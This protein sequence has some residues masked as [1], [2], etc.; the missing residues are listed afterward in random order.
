MRVGDSVEINGLLWRIQ[1]Y[2]APTDLYMLEDGT[3]RLMSMTAPDLIRYMHKWQKKQKAQAQ[4][5]GPATTYSTGYIT[6]SGALTPQNLKQ[7]YASLQQ[8][9][10]NQ[11]QYTGQWTIVDLDDEDKPP[12]NGDG[13]N[14]D[15]NMAYKPLNKG[16]VIEDVKSGGKRK[17]LVLGR[18]EDEYYDLQFEGKKIQWSQRDYQNAMR[19]KAV[20]IIRA[21]EPQKAL[22]LSE[23]DKAVLRPEAREDVIA[24]IMQAHKKELIFDTWGLGET[25]E[26]GKGIGMLFEGGPGTG[27]TWLAHCIAKAL[28]QELMVVTTG[29][30]QSSLAGQTNKNIENAFKAAREGN[31]ILFLDECDS[32]IADRKHLGMILGSEI[33]TILTCIEKAEGIT[34]LATNRIENLDPALDRR[35]ALILNFPKPNL[36]ERKKIWEI[37]IPKKMPLGEGV[38]VDTLAENKLTGGMIKNV[39]LAAARLAAAADSKEVEKRH[40]DRAIDR[41]KKSENRMGQ[42]G[43]NGLGV[44][45]YVMSGDST[46]T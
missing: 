16:D 45:D 43:N 29:Q 10:V 41:V 26:Y 8:I 32:F 33:N 22:K 31:H 34:I 2:D 42:R 4:S 5:I 13:P 24:V 35:L 38:S 20:R 15:D 7:A 11:N 27:K 23:L 21:K 28:G 36:E 1:D 9:Q 14:D 18:R 30:I 25:V 12:T 44:V 40:F 37:L 39:L 17:W 19:S 6:S 3:G 46:G